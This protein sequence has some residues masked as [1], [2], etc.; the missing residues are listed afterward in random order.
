MH[1]RVF[2]ENLLAP[3]SHTRKPK[4]SDTNPARSPRFSLRAAKRP[5]E[6]PDMHCMDCTFQA[7]LL[8]LVGSSIFAAAMIRIMGLYKY[9]GYLT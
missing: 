7:L 8:D 4:I 2:A 5:R 6:E 1:L 9:F 3:K